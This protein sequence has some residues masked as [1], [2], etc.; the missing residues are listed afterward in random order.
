MTR[1]T[2]ILVAAAVVG[3]SRSAVAA[4]VCNPIDNTARILSRPVPTAIHPDWKGDNYVGTAWG[5][6][7]KDT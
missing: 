1:P 5:V 2:I 6:I 4:E 3:M 7:V